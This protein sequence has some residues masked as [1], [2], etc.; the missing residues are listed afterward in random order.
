[1]MLLTQRLERILI[2]QYHPDGVNLGMNIGKAAGAGVAGHIHMHVLPRW[3]AD[4]SF[5]TVVGETRVLPELLETTYERL[6]AAFQSCE[7]SFDPVPTTETRNPRVLRKL[8]P[9][10]GDKRSP[11]RIRM[12]RLQRTPPDTGVF[13]MAHYGMLRDYRFATMLTIY[14]AHR[15]ME[16]TTRS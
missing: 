9:A 12:S 15:F 6:Y 16:S 14:A 7:R 5:M 8:F 13:S 3:V 1:M 11:L 10:D 2:E 4:A